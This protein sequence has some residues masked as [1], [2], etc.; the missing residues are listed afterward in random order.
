MSGAAEPTSPRARR[1]ALVALAF[2]SLVTLVPAASV[3]AA[4]DADDTTTSTTTTTTTSTTTTSSTTTT[5]AAPTTTAIPTTAAPT[6]A[7]PTTAAPTTAVP[8]TAAPTTTTPPTSE[9]AESA[10]LLAAAVVP[11][12][13][14][15]VYVT[16][17]LGS[18]G[19]PAR[20]LERRL[21]QYGYWLVGPD[22]NFDATGV[23]ALKA[24]QQRQGLPVSGVAGVATL[25]ALAIWTNP[26]PVARATCRVYVTAKLGSRGYV[27]NCVETRLRQ[28]GYWLAGPNDNFDSTAVAALRA[29]Q[30]RHGFVASGVAGPATLRALGIW[31]APPSVPPASCTITWT[32]RGGDVGYP[33]RCVESRLRQYGFWLIGPDSRFDVTAVTALRAFQSRQGLA[34]TG[35]A[36]YHTMVRLGIWRPSNFPPATCRA[37]YAVR[38]NASGVEARCVETRLVQLGYALAGSPNYVFDAASVRALR[39]FQYRTGLWADGVAG[40]NTM[41]RMGIYS[42]TPL[43]GTFPPLPA[44][45]GS[46]RRIVYS[47]AQQRIWVVES[48]GAVVKSHR[49]SGRTYEPYAGTYSVYSRSEYT[50]SAKDPSVR[51]RYMIRF[52]YGP[53]GGRIGFHEIPNRNGVPLQTK[54]QLG[55]PLSGGCVRQSTSDAYWLWNWAG[56]G[57][58]VVVL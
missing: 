36:D 23:N 42:A 45:S 35:V 7:A 5:T 58:T 57:T 9:P 37:H 4:T 24:F 53:E 38:L 44:N 51:W 41:Q 55:L 25:Q 50:Y 28:Y 46:G 15:R 54:E 33:A 48:S 29:F 27:A 17:R 12:P 30:D 56:I 52:A 21:R 6:T 32:V 1:T 47:R 19:S 26:P 31:T 20:C 40:P 49:V 18:R 16:L 11:A 39:S 2:A 43:P 8:T 13:T 10:T 14:C 3:G 22:D 34:S